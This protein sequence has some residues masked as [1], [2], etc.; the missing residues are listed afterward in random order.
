M[1]GRNR[2]DQEEISRDQAIAEGSGKNIFTIGIY[3]GLDRVD[4]N[5]LVKDMAIEFIIA[6]VQ[7]RAQKDGQWCIDMDLV[8]PDEDRIRAMM[9]YVSDEANIRRNVKYQLDEETGVTV[10]FVCRDLANGSRWA[11]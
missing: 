3:H 5:T 7:E 11:R 4:Y 8:G 9:A 2:K 6:L 10:D 1:F